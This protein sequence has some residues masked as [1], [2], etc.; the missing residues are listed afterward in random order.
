M[1]E[2]F[3]VVASPTPT[4]HTVTPH[5]PPQAL[6]LLLNNAPKEGVGASGRLRIPP[7]HPRRYN[8]G[9]QNTTEGPLPAKGSFPLLSGLNWPALIMF[10]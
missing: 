9:W 2:E 4:T 6:G 1:G 3:T 8:A 7:H 5:P 10:G